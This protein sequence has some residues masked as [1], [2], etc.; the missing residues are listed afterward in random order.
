MKALIVD[1]D[2]YVRLGLKKMV[3][4]K[5][6]D[7]TTLLFAENGAAAYSIAQS[8]EP[9]LIITD[10]KMPIMDGIELCRQLHKAQSNSHLLMLSA[11]DDFAFVRDAMAY[12]V[13]D[14]ILKPLDSANMARLL[15]KIKEISEKCRGLSGFEDMVFGDALSA[16]LQ[17]AL[18]QNDQAS[19]DDFFIDEWSILH[20]GLNEHRFL[21]LSVTDLLFSYINENND[22]SSYRLTQVHREAAL[23]IA[24]ARDGESLC[25]MVHKL[26]IN[27]M[28]E[29]STSSSQRPNPLVDEIYRYIETHYMN[30]DLTMAKI[31]RH[32]Y[33]SPGYASAL[34]RKGTGMTPSAYLSHVRIEKSCELLLDPSLRLSAVSRMVGIPDANYFPKLFKKHTGFSP[35]EFRN[36]HHSAKCIGG[37]A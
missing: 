26:Y 37:E 35:S 34:F 10:V 19:I 1:D 4:W 18:E 36:M 14:Y 23:A 6:F 20:L 22:G 16:R 30:S 28:K 11:Y 9:E 5:D 25:E 17:R 24:R 27:Q 8:E 21:A 7:F 33:I 15:E 2:R 29:R 12:N 32:L 13:R 3:P 31:A